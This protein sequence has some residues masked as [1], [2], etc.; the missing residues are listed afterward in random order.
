MYPCFSTQKIKSQ[1]LYYYVLTN[2]LSTFIGDFK[3]FTKLDI[4]FKTKIAVFFTKT[5]F[6]LDYPKVYC[7][8]NTTYITVS[9]CFKLE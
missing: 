6:V 8:V 2:P 9:V 4:I 1:T 5:T 7:T 3:K